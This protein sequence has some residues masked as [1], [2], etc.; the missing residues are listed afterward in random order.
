MTEQTI[1]IHGDFTVEEVD[2]IIRT[3]DLWFSDHDKEEFTSRL[4]HLM[5]LFNV[6][7]VDVR[8]TDMI[9]L[10][11]PTIELPQ[12]DPE[13][14]WIVSRMIEFANDKDKTTLVIN[15]SWYNAEVVKLNYGSFYDIE[16]KEGMVPDQKQVIVKRHGRQNP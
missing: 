12:H 4:Y 11:T 15:I 14:S 7:L 2:G 16:I 5:S 10:N 3:T 9:P 13:K 8:I 6:S 1:D